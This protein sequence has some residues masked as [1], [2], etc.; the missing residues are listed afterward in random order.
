MLR[1]ETRDRIYRAAVAV[2]SSTGFYS[3][4]TDKIAEAAGVSIGTVY[5][6]F[7]SKDDILGYIFEVELQR[8]QTAIEEI[9][10]LPAPALE[11][12]RMALLA[13]ARQVQREPHL[14]RLL[15]GERG[16]GSRQAIVRRFLQGIAEQF[17]ALLDDGV[18]AGDVRPCDT[19]LAARLL[20]AS[21]ES[22]IADAAL[23]GADQE[24][25]DT[26]KHQPG[27]D[28]ERLVNELL[29]LLTHGFGARARS[30]HGPTGLPN[31]SRTEPKATKE[32]STA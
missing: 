32:S 22:V 16:L 30:R 31:G 21:V 4:T 25:H 24:G 15:W 29:T 19:R 2:M 3:A 17:K 13:N 7:R 26:E 10:R 5:N 23:G 28:P 12:I 11:K 1:E 14:S 6:Y 18:A 9:R 27:Y 8:R 20:L